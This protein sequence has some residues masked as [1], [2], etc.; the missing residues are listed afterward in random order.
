V[1]AAFALV[2]CTTSST[3]SPPTSGSSSPTASATSGSPTPAAPVAMLAN[4]NPVPTCSGTFSADPAQTVSFVSGGFAYALDPDTLDTSCAMAVTDPGP[5]LWGPLGDRVLLGGLQVAGLSA[6]APTVGSTGVQPLALDW[7]H[8]V[9]IAVVYSEKGSPTPQKLLLESDTTEHF[10]QMPHGTYLDVAYH[11]SG[12]ALAYVL[13]RDGVQ[14]IWYSTNEGTDPKRLVFTKEGTTFTD[15]AFSPDGQDLT[16]IAQ[17]AEG[18]PAYHWIDLSDPSTLESGWR[19]DVGQYVSHF[20]QAPHGSGIAVDL[21][22]TCEESRAAVLA[23]PP[24]PAGRAPAVERGRMAR[25][26]HGPRERRPVRRAHRPVR[27]ELPGRRRDAA[28]DRRRRRG[29]E[30]TRA[31]GAELAPEGGGARGRLGRRVI[32]GATGG[33]SAAEVRAQVAKR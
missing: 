29:L 20:F 24:A 1:L 10:R 12:L 18:Y 6:K 14:S 5:F 8:P 4:G 25:R 30:G 15:V 28:R 27:R 7:G 23:G 17:H 33:R 16:Y 21:G 11:P 19:G 2:A 31:E 13:E 32:R 3:V 26:G 22:K 9:G